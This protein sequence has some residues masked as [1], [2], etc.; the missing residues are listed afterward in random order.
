MNKI[1]T[2]GHLNFF[3]SLFRGCDLK[4]EFLLD[5]SLC[6]LFTRYTRSSREILVCEIYYS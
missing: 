1:K 5:A 2:H 6:A 3:P 4:L